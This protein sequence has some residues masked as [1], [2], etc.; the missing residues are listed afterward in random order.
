[1]HR[2]EASH[3]QPSLPRAVQRRQVLRGAALMGAAAF[4]AACGG[5]KDDKQAKSDATAT[6]TG[7]GTAAASGNETPKPGGVVRTVQITQAPHFSPYHP[8]A[9]GSYIDV[10]RRVFGYYEVLWAFKSQNVPDR[11]ALRIAEKVEQPD[12]STYIVKMRSHSF[13]N[14]APANGREVTAEDV[15]ACIQFLMKPPAAGG[16]FLQSGKDLKSVTV[17]DKLTLRFETFGPRAFFYEEGT[18]P[19]LRRVIVP[20]EMLDEETLRRSVPVG[21]GP[22]EYKS[23]TQGSIE[24]VKRFDNYWRKPR[25]WIDERKMTFVPDDAAT[26]AAFRANQT[27]G[28]G[29]TSIKQRDAI[30]KDLGPRI[31]TKSF[32][33]TLSMNIFVNIN[34]PPWNDVRVREA[35]HRAVDV[36]R[37][38]NVVYFDDGYRTWY[39]TRARYDRNPVSFEQVKQYVGYDPKKASDLLKAAGIDPNKEYEFMVPV[40]AQSWVDSARLIAE[41]L[42]KVGL[43]MRVNPVVRNIYL[44]RAG[45]KPGD[46]DM[47]MTLPLDYIYAKSKSGTFWDSTSLQDPEVDAIIEKIE[48]TVDVKA[49]DKLS[50]D[51]QIMLAKKYSNFIPL[52]AGNAHYGWYA[53]LKGWNEEFDYF[54]NWQ[55]DVWIDKT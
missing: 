42:Q 16:S 9:D 19:A 4:V 47:S 26:E 32:P 6:G 43:K 53:Y 39:F 3:R 15:A 40:E 38:I 17:V 54:L 37:I 12:E 27:D 2:G 33:S 23:H 48:Q 55:D 50:E 51:F 36:D 5:G 44:Q 21:S 10:W 18:G 45:P 11:L 31:K 41:D 7:A 29:F 24:E 46:F 14:R 49:R 22:Y 8:G 20:K 34:R 30:V 35:V 28:I 1:M 25:P 52:V 13:H